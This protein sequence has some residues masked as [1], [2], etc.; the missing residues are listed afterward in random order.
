MKHFRVLIP[1]LVLALVLSGCS[2]EPMP[3]EYTRDGY[4][5]TVDP[6]N[7]TITS[8]TEIFTYVV[9]Y[10]DVAEWYEITFPDGSQ[11][12]RSDSGT[13]G[14][15]G[16]SDDFDSQRSSYADFLVEALKQSSPREKQGN[17]GIGFLLM[18]LG[19][20]NFFFPEL[21]FH[22]RYGWAVRDAEPSDAYITWAKIGG[23]LAAAAGLVWCII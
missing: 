11:Y 21:P 3:Y 8:D 4:T 20:V 2:G 1:L 12:W 9:E 19:A 5:V 22:L 10:T 13:M 15:G 23:V 14:A 16:W 6:V 7:R 18:A 17:L